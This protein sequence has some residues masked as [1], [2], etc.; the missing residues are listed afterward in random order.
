MSFPLSVCKMMDGGKLKSLMLVAT[1]VLCR[2]TIFKS[3]EDPLHL[4][5][6]HDP[7]N[8]FPDGDNPSTSHVDIMPFVDILCTLTPFFISIPLSSPFLTWCLIPSCLHWLSL[9]SLTLLFSSMFSK[10]P[11][12]I[13][14]CL[15]RRFVLQDCMMDKQISCDELLCYFSFPRCLISC[16][17]Q[18]CFLLL[19]LTFYGGYDGIWSN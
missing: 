7:Y 10:E 8:I 6:C 14:L 16:F 18:D 13:F 1:L 17:A 15:S 4:T 3:F 5:T 2:A 9:L 11:R 12:V 19:N